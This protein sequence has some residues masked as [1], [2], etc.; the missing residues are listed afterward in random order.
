MKACLSINTR[1][2]NSFSID[3]APNSAQYQAA[4]FSG[5]TVALWDTRKFDRPVDTINESDSI[6]KISW[7]PT[8]CGRLA[9]SSHNSSVINIYNIKSVNNS[10]TASVIEDVNAPKQLIIDKTS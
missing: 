8:K 5:N 10:L 4:S 2:V 7:C 1:Y 3:H 6:L 9:V